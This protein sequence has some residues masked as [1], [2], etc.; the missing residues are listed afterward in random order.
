MGSPVLYKQ[1]QLYGG[2]CLKS[3][4]NDMKDRQSNLHAKLDPEFVVLF[5]QL[6]MPSAAAPVDAGIAR[7]VARIS[8]PAFRRSLDRAR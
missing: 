3:D 8:N 1:L 5:D 6:A 4:A 7:L 2:S